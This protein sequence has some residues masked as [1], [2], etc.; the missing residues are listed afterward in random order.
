[1]EK[2]NSQSSRHMN[3]QAHRMNQLPTLALPVITQTALCTSSAAAA[4]LRPN[5]V[6]IPGEGAGWTS[7]SVQMDDRN[8]ASKG[9][10]VQMPT[11]NASPL[12]VC[13]SQTVMPPRPA[14]RPRAQRCSRDA[15]LPRRT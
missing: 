14:A 12:R 8:P 7:S 6:V 2:E 4:S 15:V 1:M 3:P 9:S 11:L 5:F 10:A 13:V